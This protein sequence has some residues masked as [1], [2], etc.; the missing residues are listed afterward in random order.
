MTDDPAALA[1]QLAQ[2][3]HALN[4]ATEKPS[5][6]TGTADVRDVAEGLH[7]AVEQLPQALEQLSAGIRALEEQALEGDGAGGTDGGASV[8]LRGLLN[9]RQALVVARGELRGVVEAL[10]GACGP[11]VE[12]V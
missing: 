9:A 8:P 12:G 7:L 6:F 2:Q 11:V 1:Y 3:V 4:A 5:A 10:A